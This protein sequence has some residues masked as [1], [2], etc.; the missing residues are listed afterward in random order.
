MRAQRD[1]RFVPCL[2]ELVLLCLQTHHMFTFASIHSNSNSLRSPRLSSQ[3]V[4]YTC[5]YSHAQESF[6][7]SMLERQSSFV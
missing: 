2:G 7:A 6:G 4:L 5:M 3:A 1:A